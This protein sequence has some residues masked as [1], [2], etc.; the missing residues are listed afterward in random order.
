MS[1]LNEIWAARLSFPDD[2][3]SDSPALTVTC[4]CPHGNIHTFCLMLLPACLKCIKGE[5]KHLDV[6]PRYVSVFWLV[7]GLVV[8]RKRPLLLEHAESEAET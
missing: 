4:V 1:G 6:V 2:M 7:V 3:D 5:N 8:C